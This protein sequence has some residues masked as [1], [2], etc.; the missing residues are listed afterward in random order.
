MEPV[1]VT[2]PRQIEMF[3]TIR[4]LRRADPEGAVRRFYLVTVQPRLL[5]GVALV[6]ESDQVGSLT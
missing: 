6:A 3:P 5:G 2:D 4:R 1:R